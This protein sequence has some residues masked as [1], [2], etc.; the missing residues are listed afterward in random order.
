MNETMTK[1][2]A[3]EIAGHI[4]NEIHEMLTTADLPILSLDVYEDL[5]AS[6][7]FW[8]SAI[9]PDAAML[10][11]HLNDGGD[12]TFEIAGEYCDV[13][14]WMLDLDVTGTSHPDYAGFFENPALD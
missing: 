5:T 8:R 9:E 14:S 13:Q 4:R 1:P 12:F 2:T 11:A 3:A 10:E 7:S 6:I